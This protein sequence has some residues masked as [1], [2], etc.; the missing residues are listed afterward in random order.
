M[1]LRFPQQLGGHEV[2]LMS[3]FRMGLQVVGE[4][5]DLEDGKHDEQLEGNDEPQRLAQA[6]VAKAVVIEVENLFK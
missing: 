2:G 3:L 4:E 5:E 6:H 1:P